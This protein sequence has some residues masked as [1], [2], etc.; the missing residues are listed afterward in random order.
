M[1][2]KPEA[3]DEWLQV[4]EIVE[5]VLKGKKSYR[6]RRLKRHVQLTLG[7]NDEQWAVFQE[8]RPDIINRIELEWHRCMGEIEDNAIAAAKQSPAL[9][10]QIL[11]IHDPENW[12]PVEKHEHDFSGL[13]DAELV[14]RAKGALSRISKAAEPQ[15]GPDVPV[16]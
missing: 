16:A 7:L 1:V 10:L 13:S 4:I 15:S 11:R 2:R 6:L 9:G 12:N 5:T 14:E 8:V 3:P